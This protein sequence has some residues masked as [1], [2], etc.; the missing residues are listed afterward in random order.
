LLSLLPTD[1]VRYFPGKKGAKLY[2]SELKEEL[3]RPSLKKIPRALLRVEIRVC[4][5]I[6]DTA[7]A[8]SLPVPRVQKGKEPGQRVG[9]GCLAGHPT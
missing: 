6:A 3:K 8:A 2:V 4:G 9:N 5:R 1:C 7:N